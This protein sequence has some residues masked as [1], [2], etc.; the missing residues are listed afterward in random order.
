ML[1]A[2]QSRVDAAQEAVDNLAADATPEE[3]VAARGEL[4]VAQ[5]ALTAAENLPENQPPP[6]AAE[7]L[8]AAQEAVDNLA[9]DATP[10]E[11][12]RGCGVE[13]HCGCGGLGHHPCH[14]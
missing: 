11:D 12:A 14:R 3:E 1:V 10:E 7:M 4:A 2:A 13:T 9:A 8:D 5:L 6:T